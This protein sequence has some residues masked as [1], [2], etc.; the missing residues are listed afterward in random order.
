MIVRASHDPRLIGHARSEGAVGDV[1]ALAIHHALSGLFLLPE[2]I[3]EDAA[4]VLLVPFP[5]GAQ[6]VEN[7]PRHER[8]GEQLRMRMLVLLSRRGAVIAKCADVLKAP[9][10]FQIRDAQGNGFQ[11]ARDFIVGHM[12]QRPSVVRAFDDDFMRAHRMHAVVNACGGALR[13]ALDAI[14]RLRVRNHANLRRPVRRQGE[15]RRSFFPRRAKRTRAG[16]VNLRLALSGDYPTARD[17]VFSKFHQRWSV[18]AFGR[19]GPG[20]A[21][22]FLNISGTKVTGGEPNACNGRASARLRAYAGPRWRPRE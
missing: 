6:L 15:Q 22:P 14:E 7:P 1:I 18:G 11:H 3:A 5:R 2:D 21:Y 10:A 20:S 4:L 17:G 12:R 16:A 19:K 8:G 9:V 13:M